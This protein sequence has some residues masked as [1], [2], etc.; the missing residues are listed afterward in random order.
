ML[1][2]R[3]LST[4]NNL[5]AY[6]DSL[7]KNL[8]LGECMLPCSELL[9]RRTCSLPEE[10]QQRAAKPGAAAGAADWL[11]LARPRARQHLPRA[12]GRS[13]GALLGLVILINMPLMHG[14]CSCCCEM[15]GL[16]ADQDLVQESHSE[17]SESNLLSLCRRI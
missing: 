6:I 12:E 9:S 11:R 10:Q 17:I 14:S 2:A 13:Q 7:S 1:L 16:A 3:P 15:A 8:G 5:F 4:S